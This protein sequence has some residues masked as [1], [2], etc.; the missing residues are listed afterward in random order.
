MPLGRSK[1][2]KPRNPSPG[3]CNDPFQE[4]S[5]IAKQAGWCGG[6]EE[7]GTVLDGR[8]EPSFSFQDSNAQIEF[9]SPVAHAQKLDS[10][11]RNVDRGHRI[12][13]EIEA[14]IEEGIAIEL[15]F[16]LEFLN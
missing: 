6:I 7:I 15:P 4:R 9:G 5:V 16:G 1:Q 8:R 2:R 14:N 13:L 11:T 3:I 10:Q 12:I